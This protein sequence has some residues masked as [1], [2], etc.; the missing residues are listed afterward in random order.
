MERIGEE[1][2]GRERRERRE[3]EI[4]EGSCLGRPPRPPQAL[5]LVAGAGFYPTLPDWSLFTSKY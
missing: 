1:E 5:Q 2:R 3:R 4:D